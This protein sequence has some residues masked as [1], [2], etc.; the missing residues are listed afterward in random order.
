MASF[1]CLSLLNL[2]FVTHCCLGSKWHPDRLDEDIYLWASEEAKCVR[3]S[4]IHNR[5]GCGTYSDG[6][7]AQLRYTCNSTAIL[8]LIASNP[9]HNKIA[10]VMP[11][12]LL[13][14]NLIDNLAENLSAIN[15]IILLRETDDDK[16]LRAPFI[17]DGYSSGSNSPFY[18]LK[19]PTHQFHYI[20][21]P[22][23]TYNNLREYKFAIIT[24][25]PSQSTS[26][27]AFAQDNEDSIAKGQFGSHF[28]EFTYPMFTR[29]DSKTCLQTDNCLPVGGYSVWS[30]FQDY[31]MDTNTTSQS[32]NDLIMAIT[33]MD[34]TCLFHQNICRGGN[35]NMAGLVGW[36]AS[37]EALSK[38]KH[39]LNNDNQTTHK[40]IIF[41][42][43]QGEA[44]D[45][46][47]SRKFVHDLQ[48]GSFVCEKPMDVKNYGNGCWQPYVS[49]MDFL[50]L[51]FSHISAIVEL[52]QIGMAHK[53][54]NDNKVTRTL[55]AHYERNTN[56]S[57]QQLIDYAQAIAR[58]ISIE[59]SMGFGV[60]SANSSDLPG[61]PPSS[62]WSF[63]NEKS[64][65]AGIVLT[66][67]PKEYR[68]K[69]Y[70]SVFDSYYN[71]LNIE[72]ICMSATL[73]ARLLYKMSLRDP[74]NDYNETFIAQHVNAD[75]LL[76]EQLLE[77]FLLDM[78]CDFVS[79]FAPESKDS[80]PSHYTSVYRITEDDEIEGTAQFVFRFIANLTRKSDETFGTCSRNFDCASDGRVCGGTNHG[81]YCMDSKTY[82]HSAVDT[83]LEFDYETKRWQINEDILNNSET[84][85][86]LIFAESMWNSNIGTRFYEKESDQTQLFMLLSGI[87]MVC[88][89]F[90]VTWR[91]KVYCKHKFPYLSRG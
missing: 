49:S 91:F 13:S 62:Y 26:I 74:D 28:V 53:N 34:T 25:S 51:N 29:N 16:F 73:Y 38:I 36:M 1:S 64:D 54:A 12:S 89:N 37:M 19:P 7:H 59:Q 55:Y 90:I 57:S 61:T 27:K 40:Q 56:T 32:P 87:L 50:K 58:S 75:C 60:E 63:L 43:F 65:I 86:P 88:V 47:G 46:V 30:T 21:N 71:N 42:A 76:I 48:N 41:A 67:H 8:N 17:S 39:V 79:N 77:C 72:Q 18:Y 2:F 44:Y 83:N 78:S 68:N 9:T 66:D 69:W 23:G 35:A 82:F 80:A 84:I 20:W 85:V 70:H 14:S 10:V 45:L 33:S 24:M 11:L 3:L 15:G 81:T 31:H 52:N 4:T 6:M 5:T 22:Y